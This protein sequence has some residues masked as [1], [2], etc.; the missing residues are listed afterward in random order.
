M[1]DSI[2]LKQRHDP[3]TRKLKLEAIRQELKNGLTYDQI[4]RKLKCSRKTIAKVSKS[5]ERQNLAEEETIIKLLKGRMLSTASQSLGQLQQKVANG[6]LEA[7]ELESILK[8]T[9]D[10]ATS[11]TSNES[12]SMTIQVQLANLFSSPS[13]TVDEPS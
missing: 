3:A 4:E 1:G 9:Y 11:S 2:E 5:I 6:D 8:T 12:N 13:S 10:R 7:K